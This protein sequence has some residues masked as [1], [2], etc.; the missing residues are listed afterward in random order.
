MP[1]LLSLQPNH[2]HVSPVYYLNLAW[3]LTCTGCRSALCLAHRLSRSLRSRHLV[4]QK[5]RCL[6]QETKCFWQTVKWNNRW[7]FMRYRTHRNKGV[8]QAHGLKLIVLACY[9]NLTRYPLKPDDILV[10]NYPPSTYPTILESTNELVLLHCS[11]RA[12]AVNHCFVFFVWCWR[13]WMWI[14]SWPC[15]C[16]WPVA[17][18]QWQRWWWWNEIREYLRGH[19]IVTF[20]IFP[21]INKLHS[22]HNS[23]GGGK[24]QRWQIAP[25]CLCSLIY[26]GNNMQS[27]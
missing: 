23:N 3:G 8:P 27:S 9:T 13:F 6:N 21:C 20:G 24:L 10:E 11:A 7:S 15:Q 1:W 4:F 25:P 5:R 18:K 2:A 17:I 14:R 12:M 22:F 19:D 26:T 16:F